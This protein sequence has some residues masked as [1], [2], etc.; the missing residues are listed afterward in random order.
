MLQGHDPLA[1]LRPVHL[2]HTEISGTGDL[3]IAIALGLAAAL[4]FAEL[5]AMAKRRRHS[6]RRTALDALES[7]RAEPPEHRLLLQA[8]LL[9][10]IV[11]RLRGDAAARLSGDAWLQKLDATFGTTFFTD[12]E[13]RLYFE[14][15]YRPYQRPDP[16]AV[17]SRLRPLIRRL[18]R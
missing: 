16:D 1:T 12:G 6:V 10:D 15:L 7:S 13:G 8:R 2:P 14:S 17:D 18:R 3:F 5:W 11:R 9:R 4:L